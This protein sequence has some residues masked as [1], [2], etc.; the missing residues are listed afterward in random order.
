M[1]FLFVLL[2]HEFFSVSQKYFSFER[3]I[4]SDIKENINDDNYPVI[5][6]SIYANPLEIDKVYR[7]ISMKGRIWGKNCD[8]DDY[9]DMFISNRDRFIYDRVNCEL[10]NL[11]KLL[12][13]KLVDWT[14]KRN[15][16]YF[17]DGVLDYNSSVIKKSTIGWY[18]R[19]DTQRTDKDNFLFI[20]FELDQVIFNNHKIKKEL[21]LEI[22]HT[23]KR[24]MESYDE[25]LGVKNI[26][27]HSQPVPNFDELPLV[28]LKVSSDNYSIVVTK[29]LRQYL[30]PPFGECSIY[31]KNSGQP[32]NASSHMQCY[33][34]CLGNFA[35]RLLN[36]TPLLIDGSF[37]ELDFPTNE[38]NLCLFKEYKQFDESKR[39][40]QL[41]EKCK[42]LCPIDCQ[43]VD[44][45]YSVHRTDTQ[46]GNEF[47]YNLSESERYYRKS[48]IWDSTQPM[49]AYNEESVMSFIDYLVDCGG[50]T[51]LWFGTNA[52][53][54]IILIIGSQFWTKI[55]H[56]IKV[57]LN[58]RTPVVN[59]AIIQ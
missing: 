4:K 47:W 30:E 51:G 39:I 45:S 10:F 2:I 41:I 12:D 49:F 48:L 23:I 16:I 53:D 25:T 3:I 19:E 42:N 5:S 59:V 54:L 43:T 17:S 38:T 28:D 57:Y 32:F 50:L 1:I 18:V 8:P 44:Y 55:L 21:F 58:L 46:I 56:K 7:N 37:S 22:F 36:C 24:N 9:Q 26:L 11:T 6:M 29:N 52:K 15:R 27:L 13:R 34:L 40:K 14:L 33:R 31:S 35:E 20:S